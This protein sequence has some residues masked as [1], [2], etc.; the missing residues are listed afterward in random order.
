MTLQELRQPEPIDQLHASG[1]MWWTQRAEHT[2]S[3]SIERRSGSG[4]CK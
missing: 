3:F 2:R 1:S 4:L